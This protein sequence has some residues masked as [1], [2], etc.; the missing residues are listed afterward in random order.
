MLPRSSSNKESITAVRKWEV[1]EQRN[2]EG[3]KMSKT[4]L[5]F[6]RNV[7][8]E[9][10][11]PA[12]GQT[13]FIR[14]P[15]VAYSTA[16]L[17]V[18]ILTAAFAASSSTKQNVHFENER[19]DIMPKSES[20]VLVLM[21][22]TNDA[23]VPCQSATRSACRSQRARYKRSERRSNSFHYGKLFTE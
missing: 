20:R 1:A 7:G 6:P 21:I 10:V 4:R 11:C 23:T 13:A 19:K 15:E 17:F 3:G 16:R 22:E 12:T 8:R 5:T 18:A 2:E 9:G 14:M